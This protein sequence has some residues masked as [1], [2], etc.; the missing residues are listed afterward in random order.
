MAYDYGP[1]QLLQKVE[2][3]VLQ[4][5]AIG[6]KPLAIVLNAFSVVAATWPAASAPLRDVS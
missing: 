6:H 3:F 5:A 1:W 4:E 2:F